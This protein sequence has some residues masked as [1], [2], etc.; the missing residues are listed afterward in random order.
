[1]PKSWKIWEQEVA[2]DRAN[3]EV[4]KAKLSAVDREL[5]LYRHPSWSFFATRL[6]RLVDQD[7]DIL[8]GAPIE[9][10]DKVRE[11]IKVVR[12]ILRIRE[13]LVREQAELSSQLGLE[14]EEHGEEG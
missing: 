4:L 14:V 7:Y 5:E 8:I 3:T 6:Q 13:D 1:M 9:E 11:R 12:T 2:E 10:I